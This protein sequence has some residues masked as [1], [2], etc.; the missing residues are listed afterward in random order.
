MRQG[1]RIVACRNVDRDGVW[2]RVENDAAVG[3]AAGVFNLKSET[4]IAGAVGIARRHVSQ[5]PQISQRDV[6]AGGN[7]CHA[8][9]KERAVHGHRRYQNAAQ[10][11]S[12]AIRRIGKTEIARCKRKTLV[13]DSANGFVGTR[14][15]IADCG[16]IDRAGHRC[17]RQ[18][19]I[20]GAVRVVVGGLPGD[21]ARGCA[22][23]SRGIRC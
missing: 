15:C 9:E 1:R 7:R 17:R 8:V 11:I 20:A 19:A 16:D 21:G 23:G 22:T 6:T 13:F 10:G 12:W 18:F 5:V 4:G 2:R 14:R 3:C